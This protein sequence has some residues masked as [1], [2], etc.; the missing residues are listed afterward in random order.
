MVSTHE[1]LFSLIIRVVW[2][3]IFVNS[4]SVCYVLCVT[5]HGYCSALTFSSESSFIGT[6]LN[7]M[8]T[9]V[10]VC[11]YLCILGH[12]QWIRACMRSSKTLWYCCKR[13]G[14]CNCKSL[15]R[16]HRCLNTTKE[17]GSEG[18]KPRW[19]SGSGGV[20]SNHLLFFS[21]SLVLNQMYSY[22][23]SL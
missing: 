2:F 1:I 20:A 18:N 12:S 17:T 3:R 22:V 14:D 8:C 5:R 6:P 7:L 4:C 15:W 23:G 9:K 16:T 13:H 19:I 10:N 21:I 11:M